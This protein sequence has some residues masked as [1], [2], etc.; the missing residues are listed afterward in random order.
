[1]A[2]Y[3]FRDL[4]G[5]KCG[6]TGQAAKFI[7]LWRKYPAVGASVESVF[8]RLGNWLAGRKTPRTKKQP[9]F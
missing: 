2:F 7:C 6:Q 4:M 5:A 8:E 3:E 9:R 1:M